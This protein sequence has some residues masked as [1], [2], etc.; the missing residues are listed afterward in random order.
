MTPEAPPPQGVHVPPETADLVVRY[1]HQSPV[2]PWRARKHI[3]PPRV[4]Q[5]PGHGFVGDNAAAP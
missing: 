1:V 4:A 5:S 2:W 3:W